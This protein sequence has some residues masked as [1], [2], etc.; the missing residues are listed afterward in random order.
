[1]VDLSS[2]LSDEERSYLRQLFVADDDAPPPSG[3]LRI[4]LDG[5]SREHLLQLLQRMDAELVASDGTHKLHFRLQVS[6]GGGSSLQ[7]QAPDVIER[8]GSLDRSARITPGHGE[9]ELVDEAGVLR[10]IRLRDISNSGLALSARYTRPLSL[11][12]ELSRLRLHIPGQAPLRL[13]GRVVRLEQLKTPG[14]HGLG[15]EFSDL[16]ATAQM[17]LRRYIFQH[18]N[19]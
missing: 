12:E 18:Y 16:S 6:A 17:A 13:A 14:R 15:L 3:P 1:M 2:Y 9:L 8:C 19:R 5:L 10:D 11:G 7:L 4:D